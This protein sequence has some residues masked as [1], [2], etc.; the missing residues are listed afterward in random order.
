MKNT[1]PA[2]IRLKLYGKQL[3]L[4]LNV[5]AKPVKPERMLPVLHHITN[6]FVDTGIE[7]F[8]RKGETIS[9]QAGCGACCRQPVPLAEFEAYQIAELVE[10]MPEPQ[11]SKVKG[12]FADAC[13][14]LEKIDWFNRIDNARN[15]ESD[16]K[17]ETRKV[18]IEYFYQNIACPFLE[19]ESCSIHPQRPL[20]C[21]EYLVTS[22]AENCKNPSA[23]NIDHIDLKFKISQIVRNLWGRRNAKKGGFVTMTNSLEW[24]KKNPNNF[25]KKTG[26]EWL[27][28]LFRHF[29]SGEIPTK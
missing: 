24:V 29:S 23:G 2:N 20:S 26:K 22:P 4:N 5:P 27:D 17:E 6:K 3:E 9:C 18:A 14:R 13:D 7:A 11:R 25:S 10:K 8:I 28:D 16:S 15:A 12:K 1:I 21:R 19:N